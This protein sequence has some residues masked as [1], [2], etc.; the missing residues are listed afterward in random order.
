MYYSLCTRCASV[1]PCLPPFSQSSRTRAKV[2]RYSRKIYICCVSYSALLARLYVNWSCGR[3]VNGTFACGRAKHGVDDI[4]FHTSHTQ[5]VSL[6][7]ECACGFS[8]YQLDESSFRT[9]HTQTVSLRCECA[10]GFSKYQL[11]E[12]SFR[13]SHTQTVS[14]PCECACGFSNYQL[15]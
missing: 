4:S 2:G 12:N 8:N 13:T 1:S 6:R 5:T 14:L 9:S 11:H 3:R 10:C 7:C 15:L